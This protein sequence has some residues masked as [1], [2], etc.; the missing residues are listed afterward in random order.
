MS[1]T[2]E[3]ET[4]ASTLVKQTE[5]RMAE[6]E[7]ETKK[8][9]LTSKP[10]SIS[11]LEVEYVDSDADFMVGLK[12]LQEDYKEMRTV[13]GDGNCYYRAF[14]YSLV[15]HMMQNAAEGK[16][17]LDYFKTKSWKEVLAQG[18]DE[19]ALEIFYE[20]LVDLLERVVDGKT[21][22]AA[23]HDEMNEENA[24][25][26]YCTWYL[27]VVTATHL[28]QDPDR[29]MPFL[30]DAQSGGGDTFLDINQFCAK[31]IE[32]MGQ[33]CE[34]VQVLALAEAVGVDV[35]IEYLDGRQLQLDNKLSH[36]QFGPENA[37]THLTLLYRPGHY[38]ILYTKK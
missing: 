37:T 4:D 1:V 28:K 18:Y 24:T 33:E 36:H 17:I 22:V 14:L 32:P 15:E 13:R 7:A 31:Y 29:F 8:Q 23:F 35:R 12:A 6:I 5:A 20:A 25:S 30:I 21:D 34:Q 16:K 2:N 38:D 3:T 10:C 27:R 9:P 11:Q 26:D 19:I